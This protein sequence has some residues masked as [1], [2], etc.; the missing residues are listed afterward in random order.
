MP[1]LRTRE[2]PESAQPGDFFTGT[3]EYPTTA[4]GFSR[5]VPRQ[6]IK[7]SGIVQQSTAEHRY[8]LGALFAV[9]NLPFF[10]NAQWRDLVFSYIEAEPT[11]A[12]APVDLQPAEPVVQVPADP[13]REQTVPEILATLPIGTRFK[14][15]S[16]LA[17]SLWQNRVI[18]SPGKYKFE[19][20]AP[21]ALGLEYDFS[22]LATV[23]PWNFEITFT[24]EPAPE[25]L[26][27]WEREL[28]EMEP[29]P[30]P[31]P[32]TAIELLQ[33]KPVGTRWCMQGSRR[34]RVLIGGDRYIVVETGDVF[35]FRSML[36][37]ILAD[38][39]EIIEEPA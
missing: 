14:A 29:E 31:L 11:T 13:P 5:D 19:D 28:L 32:Q 10:D 3:Y 26:A 12:P 38:K 6:V 2:N 24:P 20:S 37:T 22:A 4:G 23:R 21:G 18:T 15:R 1:N 34:L 9:S 27:Q 7:V 17:G 8:G 25:P 30:Q 16:S 36:S 35:T 33:S 39:I